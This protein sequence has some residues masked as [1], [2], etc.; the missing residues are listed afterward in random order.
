MEMA[1]P[2]WFESSDRSR[3]SLSDVTASGLE[4]RSP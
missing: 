4:H 3:E 1:S 2:L